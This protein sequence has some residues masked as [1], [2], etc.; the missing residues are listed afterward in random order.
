MVTGDQNENGLYRSVPGMKNGS[1]FECLVVRNK[2]I[3]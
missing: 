2:K 3:I 1:N